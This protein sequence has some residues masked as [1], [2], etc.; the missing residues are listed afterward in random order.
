MP[1]PTLPEPPSAPARLRRELGVG[2]A[3]LLGLGAI[4]GT[5]VFVSMALAAGIAGAAVLPAILAAALLALLNGLS[6]AQLA[7]AHPVSGGTYEYG[8][9][10][11]GPRLGFTAGWVFLLAKS[12]S[13]ATAAL[14]LAGYVLEALGLGATPL[15]PL[16][17]AALAVLTAIVVGGLRRSNRANALVVG[18]TL[19]ALAA[20][21]LLGLPELDPAAIRPAAWRGAGPAAFLQATAL[22]FVA[23]TGYGRVATLGE[24]IR[25]P[26]R[27]IPRA[28]VST[29]ALTTGVYVAVAAVAL[30]TLGGP[31]LG[32]AVAAGAA[33]LEVAARAFGPPWLAPFVA[34]GAI[35][36]MAGVLINLL[37]GLS[38][39]LLAMGRRADMPTRFARLD[40]SGSTPTAAVLAVAA[41]IGVIALVGDVGLTW[42]FSAFTVLLYYALTNA[43]A[44]RLPDAQRRYPRLQAWLGLAG[45]LFLAFWVEPAVWAFGLALVAVGL[46]WHEAARRI[47]A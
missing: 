7:A 4:L 34:L 13:A 22:L 44:L 6:S 32:E 19:L 43:A 38:R 17:L 9:R 11:L 1:P 42:S 10:F 3:V 35:T 26:A 29:L 31:A 47:R 28:I 21:C 20:F 27:N 33:P 46:L 2:G 45:C 41:L 12:A 30:G 37:L 5:G 39:V 24:E 18:L 14:G 40:A 16:A 36:A 25:E 23:F 8:Y 15:V